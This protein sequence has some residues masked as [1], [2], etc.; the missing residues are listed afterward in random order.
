M[1][2]VRPVLVAYKLGPEVYVSKSF[3]ILRRY[4]HNGR[5]VR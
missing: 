3:R 2:V 5:P 4:S 1:G